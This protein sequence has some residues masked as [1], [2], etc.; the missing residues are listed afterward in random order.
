MFYQINLIFSILYSVK[1]WNLNFQKQVAFQWVRDWWG[2]VTP[3]STHVWSK[4]AEMQER[5]GREVR[6]RGE[7]VHIGGILP[8]Q[9]KDFLMMTC[10]CLSH[11]F[12][13][14]D[15][16]RMQNHNWNLL[17]N[18]PFMRETYL[19]IPYKL[20]I[21]NQRSLQILFSWAKLDICKD[22]QG[23]C[24]QGTYILLRV[25]VDKRR[26]QASEQMNKLN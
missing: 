14:Q 4:L 16:D 17:C 8:W 20:C 10:S 3:R 23:C 2:E 26:Q 1:L 11:S 15:P 6:A 24:S 19:P 12:H 9:G 22:R 5:N 25:G 18:K 21:N 13:E 7:A